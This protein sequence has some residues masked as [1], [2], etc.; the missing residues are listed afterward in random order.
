MGPGIFLS[1]DPGLRWRGDPEIRKCPTD[2][3]PPSIGGRDA[4][5]RAFD[6]PLIAGPPLHRRPGSQSRD[7]FNLLARYSVGLDHAHWPDIQ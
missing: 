4:I 1:L 3:Y 5:Y 2:A 7:R 6:Y